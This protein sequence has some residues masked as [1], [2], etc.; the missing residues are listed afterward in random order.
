MQS[1]DVLMVPSVSAYQP[2]V[3]MVGEFT[4]KGVYVN[5]GMGN[6]SGIYQLKQGQSAAD[7]I[8]QTGGFTPQA[9]LRQAVLIRREGDAERRI[10]LDLDALIVKGDS[11][12]DVPL[13]NGDTLLLPAAPDKVQV[14]G[15]VKSPGAFDF[16][17][18]RKLL[19]YIGDAGGFTKRSITS[20]VRVLRASAAAPLV[21]KVNCTRSAKSMGVSDNPV[22]QA[23]DIIYT[24]SKA[25]GDWQDIFQMLFSSLSLASFLRAN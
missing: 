12:A 2:I 23:G 25:V 11:T 20:D 8:I 6:K 19:D 13:A 22:L 24:P 7:V 14:L 16:R 9:D 5:A 18:G 10:P 21:L 4:G 3:R 15:E 1:G 17:P